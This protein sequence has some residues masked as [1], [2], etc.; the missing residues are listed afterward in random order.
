MQQMCYSSQKERFDDP[1]DTKLVISEMICPANLL[2]STEKNKTTAR[3]K[4]TQQY[5]KHKLT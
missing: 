2:A 4:K 5:N 1:L 3:R